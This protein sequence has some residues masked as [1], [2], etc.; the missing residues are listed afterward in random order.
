MDKKT[1]QRWTKQVALR[2]IGLTNAL[3]NTPTTRVI[4]NQMLRS[5]TSVG[6]NYHA[7]CRA[8]SDADFLYKLSIVEEES[9]ESL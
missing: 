7:A 4:G 9:D 6:A 1:M 2:V 3:P 8:K 5:A